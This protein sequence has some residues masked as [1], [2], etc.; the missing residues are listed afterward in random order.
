MMRVCV[1][2]MLIRL[3]YLGVMICEVASYIANPFVKPDLQKGDDKFEEIWTHSHCL[4]I[5][6]QIPTYIRS[7]FIVLL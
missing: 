2:E 3:R 7:H 6:I 4:Y 1:V 5:Q